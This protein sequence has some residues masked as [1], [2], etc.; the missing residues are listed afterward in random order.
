MKTII[1]RVCSHTLRPRQTL[2]EKELPLSWQMTEG[3]HI[4]PALHLSRIEIEDHLAAETQKPCCLQLGV[5]RPITFK[6]ADNRKQFLTRCASDFIPLLILLTKSKVKKYH[7]QY[8]VL[9][10]LH[11]DQLCVSYH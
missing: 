9:D 7:E 6:T 8:T 11:N 4:Y 1:Q 10:S 5:N 3:T 2:E